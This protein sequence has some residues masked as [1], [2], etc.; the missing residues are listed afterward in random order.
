MIEPDFENKI[1]EGNFYFKGHITVV[2]F[3]KVVWIVLFDKDIKRLRKILTKQNKE[4]SY[5]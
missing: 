5:E 4:E 2:S 1:Y 3:L